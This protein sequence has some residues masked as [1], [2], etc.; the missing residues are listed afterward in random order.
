MEFGVIRCDS[1]CVPSVTVSE[2]LAVSQRGSWVLDLTPATAQYAKTPREEETKIYRAIRSSLIR[3][4]IPVVDF[5][6][7]LRLWCVLD[8]GAGLLPADRASFQASLL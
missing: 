4:S 8:R 5:F 3:A 6:A 2:L 7:S 1:T